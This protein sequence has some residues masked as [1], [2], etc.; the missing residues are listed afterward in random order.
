MNDLTTQELI[1]LIDKAEKEKSAPSKAPKNTIEEFIVKLY[2]RRGIDRVPNY[3][4]F[5]HYI[6]GFQSTVGDKFKKI[7][8]FREFNKHFDQVRTG[9]Q[10]YYLV[11]KSS[12]DLSREGILNAKKFEKEY[13]SKRKSN[14]KK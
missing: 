14:K 4:I 7:G 11:D 6:I 2:I 12:F 9:K 3:I 10:R 1:D 13:E 5:Y 8:F